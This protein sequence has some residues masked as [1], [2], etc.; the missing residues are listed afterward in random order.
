[1]GPLGASALAAR[2]ALPSASPLGRAG[3]RTLKRSVK[4]EQEHA[5]HWTVTAGT[6]SFVVKWLVL[7][8]SSP[9]S[10]VELKTLQVL[11][12]AGDHGRINV[13]RRSRELDEPLVVRQL[14]ILRWPRQ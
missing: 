13:V 7:P 6:V 11:P 8:Q 4:T 12:T 5:A 9:R 2:P 14:V 1:M 3:A 10:S